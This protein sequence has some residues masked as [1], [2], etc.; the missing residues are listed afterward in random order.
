[1]DDAVAGWTIAVLSLLVPACWLA[2]AH[3]TKPDSTLALGVAIWLLCTG[4][5]AFAGLLNHPEQRPPPAV[6]L[7]V[8]GNFT[9][10]AIGL[11][12]RG[13]QIAKQ[14]PLW[15]LVGLQ[16]FRL[17]LELAMHHAASTGVMPEQM[18]WSGRNFDV[19]TGALAIP[20]SA[21]LAAGYLRD[22]VVRLWN[23]LGLALLLNVVGIAAAST[24]MLAMFGNAPEQLNT[25]IFR[26]PYLWLPAVLVPCALLGHLTVARALGQRL[27]A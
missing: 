24:P 17:P 19:V 8:L 15:V 1:M 4:V 11:S 23:G 12:E 27:R 13:F 20:I 2:I 5:L 3:R 21:L 22:W 10:A 18:T 7:F 9:V 14:T 26:F 6:A 16:A 25:W